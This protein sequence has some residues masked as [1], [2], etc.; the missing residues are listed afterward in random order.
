GRARLRRDRRRPGRVAPRRPGRL[1]RPATQAANHDHPAL[2]GGPVGRG[3]RRAA[4]MQHRQ[5][6]EPVLTLAGQA[7][8]T[9]RRPVHRAVRT[10]IPSTAPTTTT[11]TTTATTTTTAIEKRN[12]GTPCRTCT[13]SSTPPPTACRRCPTSP[14]PPAGSSAAESSP[15]APQERR[16]AAPWSSAPARS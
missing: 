14:P 11:A 15:H 6:Q 12:R 16:S 3:D 5:R 4:G 1:A 9:A 2:L 13:N 7:A 8:R 10:L